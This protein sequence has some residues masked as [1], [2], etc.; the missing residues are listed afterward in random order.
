MVAASIKPM[1]VRDG[2]IV[3]I[4]PAALSVFRVAD[5]GTLQ[6]VRTY[7][8]ETGERTHYWMGIVGLPGAALA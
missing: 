1:P 2:D 5:D 4:A 6:F 3:R 8:V 7:D